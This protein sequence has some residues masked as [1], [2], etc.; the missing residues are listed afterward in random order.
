MSFTPEQTAKGILATISRGDWSLAA[1]RL[2][3]VPHDQTRAKVAAIVG[4]SL[5]ADELAVWRRYYS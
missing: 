4:K 5:S 2:R 1:S 3:A